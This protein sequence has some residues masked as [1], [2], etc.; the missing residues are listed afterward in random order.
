MTFGPETKGKHKN[1]LSNLAS[2]AQ[3]EME[4]GNLSA[5]SFCISNLN[6]GAPKSANA[7]RT[8][9]VS[10]NGVCMIDILG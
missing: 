2:H 9:A 6:F 5:I 10:R 4:P 7:E 1:F 8:R 3:L